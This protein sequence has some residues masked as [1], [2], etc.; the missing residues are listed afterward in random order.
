[1]IQL[2]IAHAFMSDSQNWHTPPEVIQF[3]EMLAKSF[4]YDLCGLSPYFSTDVES[5]GS[6]EDGLL[7]FVRWRSLS[8]ASIFCNPPYGYLPAQTIPRTRAGIRMDDL[9]YLPVLPGGC[10]SIEYDAECDHLIAQSSSKDRNCPTFSLDPDGRHTK[11]DGEQH[12][13]VNSRVHSAYSY[14]IYLLNLW[15][16]GVIR[17]ACLVIP[18]ATDT[19]GYNLLL[20]E[21]GFCFNVVGRIKFLNPTDDGRL[22]PGKQNTKGTTIFWLPPTGA[23]E[24]PSDI[25]AKLDMMKSENGGKLPIDVTPLVLPN[26]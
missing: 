25:T 22:V 20:R 18:N 19:L 4:T 5:A 14:A 13:P 11:F 2:N 6:Y 21:V 23:I 3:C 24:R 9:K 17:Q 1:M 15:Q 10:K 26:Y 16:A 12:I 7:T 8:A